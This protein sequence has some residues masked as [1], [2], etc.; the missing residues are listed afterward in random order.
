METRQQRLGATFGVVRYVDGFGRAIQERRDAEPDAATGG[1]RYRV[2]GW[3][4]FNH[5]G[6][7]VKAYQPVFAD[8]DAYGG[9]D[10]TTAFVAMRYDP[11]GRPVRVDYPDGSFESTSYHPW[12]QVFF[13]RNDNA[14]HIT[15]SDSRYGAFV[16]KFKRHVGTPKRSFVDALGRVIAEVQDDGAEVHI[17]R[18]VMDFKDRVTEVWDARGLSQATWVFAYDLVG[19]PIHTRHATALGDRYAL[20]D[21]AGNPVWARDARGVEVTRAFDALNRPLAEMSLKGAQPKLRRQWRYVAYDQSAPEFTSNQAKNLFRQIEEERDADGLRYFEYDWRGLVTKASHRLW[22]QA[23]SA[24]RGWDNPQSELWTQGANWDPEIPA[25]DRDGIASYQ[26]LPQLADPVTLAIDTRYDAAGRPTDVTYPEGMATRNRYNAAG[27]LERLDIDRGTG[28]G[29]QVVVEAIRYNARGQLAYLRHGNGVETMR[30]YDEAL[31]RLTRIFTR[32]TGASTTHFQDLG[33]GY[34]PVGNP[35]EITDRL[36]SSSF[37][38]NQLIPNTRTFAYDPRYRLIEATGKKHGSVRRKD[39]YVLVP[40]SD[41]N[42]YE[43]YTIH[44]AYDAAGNF[45]RNQEYTAGAL[46]YKSDRIDL[47]NGDAAEAGSFTDPGAGNFRY[48]ANGNTTHTPRH[49]SLAYTHD[50]QVRYVNLKGGGQVQ[51]LRHGDQRVLRLVK[52]NGVKALTVYLGPFEYHLRQGVIG[53]TKLVLHGVGYGR[54]AQAERV[55]AGS[56]PESLPL[57]FHHADHL[58]SGHVLTKDSGDVLSQEEY[59]PYGGTSDRRDARNR[60]RF[61]GVEQD[62]STRLYMTGPRTYDCVSGR[63]L[64]TRSS[65]RQ[66]GSTCHRSYTRARPQ[67]PARSWRIHRQSIGSGSETRRCTTRK[68][69]LSRYFQPCA[70]HLLTSGRRRCC[71][72]SRVHRPSQHVQDESGGRSGIQTEDLDTRDALRYRA[73]RGR[74][75]SRS[76]WHHVSD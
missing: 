18:K 65:W 24:G 6:L 27:L 14:G 22:S 51:Y 42:D 33:Y 50:N 53:Y 61:I 12:V 31:E 32:R 20:A 38:D 49:E 5:K 58:G 73:G 62:E 55:L 59:F 30:E 43:P 75:S 15:T 21:A 39:S 16:A 57:F 63:F 28:Q 35:M 7:V 41:P 66:P 17:I 4:V 68:S 76:Q 2:T 9:G 72:E 8:S 3:L 26:K 29:L 25:A 36:S 13:D 47:F 37:K 67:L 64:Q 71:T 1:K 10:T 74:S 19:R 54:H 48:D 56:D 11:I 44:Y 69:W 23:D 60:Y 46:H 70:R 45:T 40:S 34:D 52:K